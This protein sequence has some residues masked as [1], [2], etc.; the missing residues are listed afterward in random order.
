MILTLINFL[1]GYLILSLEGDF[2]ERFLNLCVREGIYLWHVK[3]NGKK[4]TAHVSVKGF[5]RMRVPC[6]KTKTRV[7]IL[8]KCGLPLFLHRHRRRRAFLVGIL[9]FAAS[10]TLLSSFIWSVE[11]DGMEKTDENLIRNALKACGLDTGVVK[12]TLKASDIKADMLRRMPS[13]SW[14]WVEV[15]GTRAFVHVREK[16]EMPE[17]EGNRP[18]NLVSDKD[19]VIVSVDATRGKAMVTPGDAVKK[20][21]LLISGTLETKHGGTLLVRSAGL[22]RARTW[23]T[24]SAA[25]PLSVTEETK[26]GLSKTRYA[27]SVGKFRLPLYY[28]A[29]FSHFICET[30][31]FPLRLWGDIVLPLTLEKESVSE[32]VQ[33][34]K[35][36]SEAEAVAHYGEQLF[37][38]LPLPEEAEVI[39][40]AYSHILQED[41]TILVTVTAEC[42]ETIGEIR[43]ILEE[44]ND[45][46][47][48]F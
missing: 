22:V 19:G 40:K 2:I 13:L 10:L 43:E 8:R 6:R 24:H 48:I 29:P 42:I 20:G 41:G 11:I 30:E 45:D 1:R 18:A 37:S 26:T 4:A 46:G 33:N 34:V 16:T 36:L 47:E 14:V 32:T 5:F 3:K 25:F 28:G 21:T 9:L 7:R 44:T 17:M 12:Y 31:S 15:K 35:Q 39:N 27:L 23:Y 38:E